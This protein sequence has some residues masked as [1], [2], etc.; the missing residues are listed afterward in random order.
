[1]WWVGVWWVE[2]WWVGVLCG[3]LWCSVVCGVGGVVWCSE[4]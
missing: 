4:V 1:M 3:R 2:V